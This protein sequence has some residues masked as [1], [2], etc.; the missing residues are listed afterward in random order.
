[1]AVIGDQNSL[2]PIPVKHRRGQIRSQPLIAESRLILAKQLGFRRQPRL[3]GQA[4]EPPATAGYGC[5]AGYHF[6]Q[7][8][9]GLSF[10]GVSR[11]NRLERKPRGGLW[12]CPRD[13]A[14]A[15]KV[16]QPKFAPREHSGQRQPGIRGCRR[17]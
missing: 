10:T 1:M 3:Q 16:S 17:Q 2:E 8:G 7:P 4:V 11:R 5:E 13:P 12:F 9:S 6:A 14:P 15:A